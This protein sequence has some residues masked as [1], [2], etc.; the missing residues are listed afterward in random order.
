MKTFVTG[1]ASSG[2]AHSP[3]RMWSLREWDPEKF[4]VPENDR[5]DFMAA[6]ERQW[7][8]MEKHADWKIGQYRQYILNR[9]GQT[10]D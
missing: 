10:S 8:V 3:M 4:I 7:T 6:V 1:E 5:A 2:S 9:D